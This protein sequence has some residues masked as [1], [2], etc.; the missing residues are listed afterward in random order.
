VYVFLL[1]KL[2]VF[3]LS[4][5]FLEFFNGKE[6][7]LI[8]DDGNHAFRSPAAQTIT[9]IRIGAATPRSRQ[10]TSPPVAATVC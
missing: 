4:H 5:I 1:H 9:T 6:A 2:F 10:I 3:A 7:P 8:G